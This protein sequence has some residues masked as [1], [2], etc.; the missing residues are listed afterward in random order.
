[1][2]SDSVNS[3]FNSVGHGHAGEDRLSL[4]RCMGVVVQEQLHV[5]DIL[6][7]LKKLTHALGLNPGMKHVHCNQVQLQLQLFKY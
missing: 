7:S 3:H 6:E 4:V 1:M 5:P 2:E